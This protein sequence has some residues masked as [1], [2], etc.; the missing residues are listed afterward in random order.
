M[1][2][3]FAN[4]QIMITDLQTFKTQQFTIVIL[5][6][7]G[8]Q[9]ILPWSSVFPDSVPHGGKQM[10]ACHIK[11]NSTNSGSTPSTQ[12]LVLVQHQVLYSTE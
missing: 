11:S 12:L 2:C 4:L 7:G 1:F 3:I 5:E 10:R 8:S 6:R 9:D